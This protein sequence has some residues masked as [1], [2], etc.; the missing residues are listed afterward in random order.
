MPPG[1]EDVEWFGLGPFENYLDRRAG[2]FVARQRSQVEDLFHP[3]VRPQSHGNRTGM[4]RLA[5]R[6]EDGCGLG[7]VA[8]SPLEFSVRHFSEEALAR[9]Q[10]LSELIPDASTHVN[11]DAGQRGVGTGA[12]GP[13]TLPRYRIRGGRHF[14]GY[15]LVLL[16]VGDSFP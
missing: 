10:H 14:F 7:F 15:R 1:H 11:L 6:R 9:A 2:V 12:C 13:D 3:Y 16:E 5:I 8:D 4:R